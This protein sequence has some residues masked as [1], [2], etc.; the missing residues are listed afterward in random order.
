[1]DLVAGRRSSQGNSSQSSLSDLI[2]LV[3][4]TVVEARRYS[5]LIVVIYSTFSFSSSLLFPLFFS[6]FLTLL[7][8]LFT[9]ARVSLS[10]SLRPN[11]VVSLSSSSL[12]THLPLPS[13]RL[14]TLLPFFFS[15]SFLFFRIELLSFLFSLS[16]IPKNTCS[17]IQSMKII[18]RI[19]KGQEEGRPLFS[20]EYFSPK[21]A[22]V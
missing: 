4:I 13:D 19:K 10:L 15:F 14:I 22:Q 18:D 1:M 2:P 12:I 6:S 16:F 21:T 8:P 20:F 9:L 5:S 3:V 17:C 7:F 11:Q